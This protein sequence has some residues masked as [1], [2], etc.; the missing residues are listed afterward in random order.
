[1]ESLIALP[2]EMP[3][4]IGWMLI[5]FSFVASWITAAFGIGGGYILLGL[6]ANVLAPAALIPV[7]G[8]IQLGSSSGRAA[9]LFKHINWTV[10]MPFMAG[11]VVG[12]SLGGLLFVQIPPWTVQLGIGLF[13]MWTVVGKMPELN[14]KRI[15]G[16]AIVSSFLI[17]FLG[18]TANIIAAIVKS[19]N[20]PPQSHVGTHAVLMATQHVFKLFIFGFLGFAYTPYIPFIAMM[21]LVGLAGTFAGKLMLA[22]AGNIYFRPVLNAILFLLAARLI[23]IGVEG[24]IEHGF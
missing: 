22:R 12:A 19:L 9:M 16:T 8:A 10:L 21:I 2:P 1:M 15:F 20:L 13:I 18:S 3:A 23:W 5:A 7:H 17:I 11:A 14:G 24:L 6:M 4:H